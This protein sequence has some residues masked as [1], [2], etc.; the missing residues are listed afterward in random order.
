MYIGHLSPLP[1][2]LETSVLHESETLGQLYKNM[3]LP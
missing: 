3:V 1:T 2:F